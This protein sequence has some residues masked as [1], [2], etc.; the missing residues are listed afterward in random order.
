MLV[1]QKIKKSLIS[2]RI[3]TT[4]TLISPEGMSMDT[5]SF[6]LLPNKLF[7]IGDSIEIL[8]SMGLTSSAPT[9]V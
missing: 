9:M 3:P 5:S 1:Y 2:Y 4:F 8:Y 7:Q 6:T